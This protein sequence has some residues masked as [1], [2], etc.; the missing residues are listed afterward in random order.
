MIESIK[1][2]LDHGGRSLLR[3][4][5]RPVPSRRHL[6]STFWNHGAGDIDLPTWWILLLQ[7]ARLSC[8]NETSKESTPTPNRFDIKLPV[9]F[10]E[11]LYPIR[12]RAL[13]KRLDRSATAHREA[14]YVAQQRT[15]R[16][17][18][19]AQSLIEARLPTSFDILSEASEAEQAVHDEQ[20]GETDAPDD[21]LDRL[22]DTPDQSLESFLQS[23]DSKDRRKLWTMYLETS[24]NASSEIRSDLV[25]EIFLRLSASISPFLLKRSLAVFSAIPQDELVAADFR[26]ATRAAVKAGLM[27]KAYSILEKAFETNPSSLDVGTSDV[28]GLAVRT[29]DWQKAIAI[30]HRFWASPFLYS[31]ASN[32]WAEVGKIGVTSLVTYATS[33]ARFALS[34]EESVTAETKKAA[35][36]FARILARRVLQHEEIGHSSEVYEDLMELLDQFPDTG[37]KQ[38]LLEA[39]FWQL[40]SIE[41]VK[42]DEKAIRMYERLREIPAFKPSEL[43]LTV[44]LKLTYSTQSASA[45]WKLFDDYQRYNISLAPDGY[46]LMA[47]TCAHAGESGALTALLEDFKTKYGNSED[48]VAVDSYRKISNFVLYNHFKRGDIVALV[49]TFED[50]QIRFGFL[51]NTYSYNFV[52]M[53]YS[54]NG[55]FEDAL[56]WFRKL[57]DSPNLPDT[58]S[59]ATVMSM[60]ARRGDVDAVLG[61]LQEFKSRELEPDAS[62]IDALV[63]VHIEDNRLDEAEELVMEA[64]TMGIEGSRTYMWNI[65]L[66]SYAIV[67]DIRKVMELSQRMRKFGVEEDERTYSAIL[68]AFSFVRLPNHAMPILKN[69][70]PRMRIQ[71]TA[72]HYAVVMNGFMET[73]EPWI[74]EH[75]YRYMLEDRVLPDGNIYNILLRAAAQQDKNEGR[76][77]NMNFERARQV[78]D[79]AIETLNPEN[80]A[81]QNARLFIKG[82]NLTQAFFSL[83]YE[84]MITLYGAAKAYDAVVEAFNKWIEKAEE[85][86]FGNIEENPPVKMLAAL[87]AV[88]RRAGNH[89][90]V[91]RCWY[92]ALERLEHS[93]RR[94]KANT[95]QPGWVLPGRRF[96]MNVPFGQYMAYLKDEG[97][98]DDLIQVVRELHTAGFEILNTEWNKYIQYLGASARADHQ[99]LAFELCEKELM[100]FWISFVS[101]GPNPLKIKFRL[102]RKNRYSMLDKGARFPSYKTFIQLAAVFLDA[103]SGDW[104][105]ETYMSRKRIIQLAPKTV[106]ALQ[107]LPQLDDEEQSIL[108]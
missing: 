2:C 9:Y 15:R 41:Y 7:N 10:L 61:L 5:K 68:M 65:L 4:S 8:S 35:Y 39:A 90:E 27:E 42:Y 103:S 55:S 79:S 72:L 56:A 59:Y 96:D 44:L 102:M 100:P 31:L 70:I 23:E 16:F 46:C 40:Q 64:A 67:C 19:I 107:E 87:L 104:V 93:C 6:H 75:L 92:L 28:L 98:L 84:Y 108:R 106:R 3:T 82:D 95:S 101:L 13:I 60:F 63:K 99:Y 20:N 80:Y 91:N 26:T 58:I 50:L 48:P 24:R 33:A 66:E 18:S 38:D 97:R 94:L 36:A 78:F 83:P 43:M 30:W 57:E 88:H 71:R 85:F 52:I 12:T 86:G 77:D 89:D 69:V 22:V 73:K 1:G 47:E 81:Q 49:Q 37:E 74:V 62:I 11:F 25:R 29:K 51:P 76:S 105:P 53:G 45:C 21:K 34:I 17:T 54:Q 32:L 14:S